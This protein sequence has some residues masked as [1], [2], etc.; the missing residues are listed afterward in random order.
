M[1][2]QEA[3]KRAYRNKINKGFNTTDVCKEICFMQNEV[4]EVFEAYF[5]NKDTIGEELADVVIFAMGIAEILG[6]DLE[7]EI[8][9]KLDINDKRQYKLVSGIYVKVNESECE[10]V[11]ENG[12][13]EQS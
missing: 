12:N 3:Q 7:S 8:I 2:M 6:K 1:N 9:R 5:K 10:Q 11:G 4:S 13:G